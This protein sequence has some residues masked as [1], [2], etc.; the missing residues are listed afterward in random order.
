[1]IPIHLWVKCRI[2]STRFDRTRRLFLQH[3]TWH[4]SKR[5]DACPACTCFL[6]YFFDDIMRWDLSHDDR[7]RARKRVCVCVC[8]CVHVQ[9]SCTRTRQ[10][11]ECVLSFSI[12][13]VLVLTGWWTLFTGALGLSQG[14]ASFCLSSCYSFLDLYVVSGDLARAAIGVLAIVLVDS[15]FC[16]TWWT[17]LF[18]SCRRTYHS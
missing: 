6:A 9:L 14:N 11:M 5:W 1:M 18:R 7:I 10:V 15:S 13:S 12:A 17:V 16:K 4:H 3:V 8:V 2:S